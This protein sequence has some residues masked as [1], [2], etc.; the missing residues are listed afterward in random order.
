MLLLCCNMFL[1]AACDN[2][3]TGVL[4]D[5]LD[6]LH[7]RFLAVNVS[8]ILMAPHSQLVMLGNRTRELQVQTQSPQGPGLPD[9]Q[10]KI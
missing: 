5:D 4:L 6:M 3:C 1:P 7:N 2:E 10:V 8:N 9:Q